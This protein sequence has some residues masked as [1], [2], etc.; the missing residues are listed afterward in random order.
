MARVRL[1]L[2]LL[3]VL[4]WVGGMLCLSSQIA[5]IYNSDAKRFAPYSPKSSEAYHSILYVWHWALALVDF[6]PAVG[7]TLLHWA[8]RPVP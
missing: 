5:W 2:R 3:I 8:L 6:S 1:V 4:A 7:L